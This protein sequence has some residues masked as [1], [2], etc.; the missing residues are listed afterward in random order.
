[1]GLGKAIEYFTSQNIPVAIPLNDTQ[2]YD[3][4][5]DID[6][7]LKK[8]SVKTSRYSDNGGKTWSVLLK[9]CGGSSGNFKLRKFD[10]T[11]C[12]YVFVYTG[13]NS[14]YLI[15]SNEIDAKNSI[16]VGNKYIEYQVRAKTLEEYT[17]EVKMQS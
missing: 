3:L 7:E 2:K 9:N 4:I 12:D 15:P 13:D 14:T 11:K 6:D 8:I 1:M 16:D 5:A 17:S 10:N